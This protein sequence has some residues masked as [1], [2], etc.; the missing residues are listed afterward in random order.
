MRRCHLR[1]CTRTFTLCCALIAALGCGDHEPGPTEQRVLDLIGERRLA[2]SAGVLS[3]DEVVAADETWVAV[4]LSPGQRVHTRLTLG[5]DASL[6]LGG[7]LQCG[8]N[9]E[10]GTE[11]ILRV[12]LHEGRGGKSHFEVDLGA[13]GGWWTRK[14]AL[15]AG[16]GQ[17]ASLWLE[18]EI[19][20]GCSLFLREATVIHQVPVAE[21]AAAPTQILLISVDTLRGD[22]VGSLGGAVQTPS[23]DRFVSEAEAWSRHYAAASWTKPSHASMLTG[24][25]PETHRA[26][27]LEQAMDPG[28][29]T[30]AG[31]LRS[32]GLT[33]AALV[34]DC[35]WL[36]PRW[37]FD[38]GF[39]S[40]RVT[41]WRAGRQARMAGEWVLDH[42][43]ENF[44]F[45]L[46]TF[47]PHSDFA[48]LPYEAPGLN[49]MSI[50]QRFS[51]RG[52][53]CRDGLCAS[54]FVNGLHHGDVALEEQDAE[55]LR[56][57][58]DEGVRY[59]DGALGQ[60]FD[61]L[62]ASGVWEQMLVVVTSD[63]GEAFGERGEFGHN[64]VH[65]EVVRVPLIIKW[66]YGAGRGEIHTDLRS[67]IDVAPTLLEYAGL[68]A[69]GLPGQD[70]RA[71]RQEEA[72]F[73]GT[74]VK[75]VI[76]GDLKGIF[77]R[78]SPPR[79]YDL[80]TDPGE[81]NQLGGGDAVRELRG[82]L[83]R[84]HQA[85]SDLYRR[86]GSQGE[87]NQVD[88]SEAERERLRAFGYVE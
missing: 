59:L 69:D 53:G 42:R 61:T 25:Y 46:H 2:S 30:L 74:L 63:H 23:L 84:H 9:R 10:G 72:V 17:E 14:V 88:L 19:D 65:E 36:S 85:S 82:L 27:N 62:R 56:Y 5:H 6:T 43:D 49:R 55:I 37:G 66:P 71:P 87:A 51:V 70:L 67:A 13:A 47:E 80:A 31:R 50:A 20:E 15:D 57:T 73:T 48:I 29:P 21:G 76:I 1:R 58:Y 45:F 44:F 16:G 3:A 52:F 7:F 39:D 34:F 75:A 83:R 18:P 33:T 32:T 86:F 41:R 60:L 38:K 8:E 79:I 54:Q 64:T 28:I 68:S 81:E 11:G 77:D 26:I 78:K 12:G 35:T 24:F 22:A 4:A 40:Y